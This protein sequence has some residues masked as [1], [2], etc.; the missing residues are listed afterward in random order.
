MEKRFCTAIV[1]AVAVLLAASALVIACGSSKRGGGGGSEGG[2][3]AVCSCS[4]VCKCVCLYSIEPT[5]GV[6]NSLSANCTGNHI[7][8]DKDPNFQPCA[9]A[10]QQSYVGSFVAGSG[11][12][13]CGPLTDDDDNDDYGYTC[14]QVYDQMYSVCDL[15]FT[16]ASGADI[17]ENE[18]VASCE[19]G[20]SPYG[21]EDACGVC[22][23]D[24]YDV[25]STMVTCLQLCASG[26]DDN[27]DFSPDDDSLDPFSLTATANGESPPVELQANTKYTFAF[28]VFNIDGGTESIKELEIALPS[29]EYAL[30]GGTLTPP[31]AI[32]PQRGAWSVAYVSEI[33]TIFWVF[34][35]ANSAMDLGDIEQGEELTFP[36]TAFTDPADTDGFV[37]TLTGD[38][39]TVVSSVWYFG[40]DGR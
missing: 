35:G 13:K 29:P 37:W 18:V 2:G 17:P 12:A 4:Y 19:A 33:A 38:V 10:C 31:A 39:S 5:E 14:Q 1:C 16:D 20:V 34:K 23:A 27:D 11:T 40:D 28:E 36:F 15:T 6:V 7:C 8:D 30:D 22:I 9:D 24:G 3:D 32:H 26:D 21:L 25:C